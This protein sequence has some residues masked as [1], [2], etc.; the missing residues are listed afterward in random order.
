MMPHPSLVDD[1]TQDTYLKLARNNFNALRNFKCD[2][3]TPLYGYI[4]KAACNVVEDERRRRRVPEPEPLPEIDPQVPNGERRAEEAVFSSEV[5]EFLKKHAS[6]RDRRIFW[7]YYRQELTS[8]AI[9]RLPGIGLTVDGVESAL[10][11]LRRQ[12]RDWG[13]PVV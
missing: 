2:N 12:L 1:L 10:H 5:D 13:K 9:S 3:E 6:E 8:E 7:L 11:R 4:K